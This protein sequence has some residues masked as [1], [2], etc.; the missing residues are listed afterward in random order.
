MIKEIL[1]LL[2]FQQQQQQRKMTICFRNLIQIFE[3]FIAKNSKKKVD[4]RISFIAFYIKLN[5]YSDLLWLKYVLKYL[6]SSYT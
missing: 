6:H 1:L 2:K 5:R 3:Q 4:I